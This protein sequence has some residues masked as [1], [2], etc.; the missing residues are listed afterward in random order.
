MKWRL[1]LALAFCLGSRY[2]EAEIN[3]TLAESQARFGQVAGQVMVLPQ[4]AA[5]WVEAQRD[6]PIEPGDH[7]RTGEESS[8]EIRLSGDVLWVLEAESDFVPERTTVQSGRFNLSHGSVLGKVDSDRAPRPQHWEFNTPSAVCAVRGTEFAIVATREAGT[9]LAVFEGE[10]EMR[11][12]E[13]AQGE[14]KPFRIEARQEGFAQRGKAIQ[15]L[16]AFSPMM[17]ERT[18]RRNDLRARFK[19]NQDTWSPITPAVRKDFRGKFVSPKNK[20][21]KRRVL[22]PR[23]R[24]KNA[25]P[26]S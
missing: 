1:A 23:R 24:G 5:D 10:V 6:M 19:K 9:R 22:P 15:V 4:G 14:G 13:T 25:R 21:P 7:I 26:P 17:I 18:K 20:L 11:E 8:A 3:D 12:A 2:L 16:K